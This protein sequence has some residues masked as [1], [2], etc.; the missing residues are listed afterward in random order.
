MP[1]NSLFLR[2][3]RDEGADDQVED[4]TA[5]AAPQALQ[6]WSVCKEPRKHLFPEPAD[7]SLAQLKAR[8]GAQLA[9]LDC[10]ARPEGVPLKIPAVASLVEQL[11]RQKNGT[12]L[13]FMAGENGG[14]SPGAAHAIRLGVTKSSGRGSAS[15]RPRPSTR[16]RPGPSLSPLARTS[17]KRK[18]VDG[19]RPAVP[20]SFPRDEARTRPAYPA[21]M[22]EDLYVWSLLFS[23]DKTRNVTES[24][25]A[26][27]ILRHQVTGYALGRRTT[28]GA[29][30]WLSDY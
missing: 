27:R 3:P 17:K 24:M 16:T 14:V 29:I 22:A 25:V 12:G 5:D 7:G 19:E 26:S 2:E 6:D 30:P 8:V 21:Y 23:A 28:L 20:S 4:S 9:A 13:S 10:F 11:S 1:I 15:F 18:N